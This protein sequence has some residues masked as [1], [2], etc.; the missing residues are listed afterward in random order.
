VG[1]PEEPPSERSPVTPAVARL[2]AQRSAQCEAEGSSARRT[3]SP[4]NRLHSQQ[5]QLQ[6]QS[7]QAKAAYNK[8]MDTFKRGFS[9]CMDARGYSV[10]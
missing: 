1:L 10:N 8:Q 4:R 5:A 6:Q 9:A 3:N 7:S 2:L